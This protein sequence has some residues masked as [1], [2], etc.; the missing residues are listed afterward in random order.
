MFTFKE[1]EEY[2]ELIAGQNKAKE[3]ILDDPEFEAHEMEAAVDL[4]LFEEGAG[5][6][7]GGGAAEPEITRHQRKALFTANSLKGIR[8]HPV[9]SNCNR[10]S[11]YFGLGC[12]EWCADFVSY[13]VDVTGIA[14]KKL[15]WGPPSWVANIT[16]WGKRN[17]RVFPQPKRGDIFTRKDGKHTGFVLRVHGSGF[18]S[19]EGNTSGPRGDVYVANKQ[20]DASSGLYHF[21]R[22]HF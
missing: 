1:L 22:W 3:G 16:D 13:C 6:A 12:Q 4:I 9:G 17:G 18:M 10:Y 2:P 19:I 20:R 14:D 7:A 21:V 5:A 11:S 8:E 15:P